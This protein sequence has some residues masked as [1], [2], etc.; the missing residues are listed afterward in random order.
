MFKNDPFPKVPRLIH[1]GAR[2]RFQLWLSGFTVASPLRMPGRQWKP[3]VSWAKNRMGGVRKDILKMRTMANIEVPLFNKIVQG[4][5][6]SKQNESKWMRTI[7]PTSFHFVLIVPAAS[8]IAPGPFFAEVGMR[9]VFL[10]AV[11]LLVGQVRGSTPA[12]ALEVD[13]PFPWGQKGMAHS[14]YSGWP[15]RNPKSANKMMQKTWKPKS[16]WVQPQI[17]HSWLLFLKHVW[18]CWSM[19]LESVGSPTRYLGHNPHP[20]GVLCPEE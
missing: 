1:Q 11:A 15:W 9:H 14:G 3:R 18:A 10:G 17:H 12:T 7:N 8:V 20:K 6:R 16:H 4:E 13:H 5:E 19:L 2:T